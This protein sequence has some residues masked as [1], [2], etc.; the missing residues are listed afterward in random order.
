MRALLSKKNVARGVF[1]IVAAV[2]FSFIL[3]GCSEIGAFYEE[4]RL[5]EEQ[6]K[7]EAIIQAQKEELYN[8]FE[9][10][11]IEYSLGENK[12]LVVEFEKFLEGKFYNKDHIL[13]YF[14]RCER[15]NSLEYLK[16][17]EQLKSLEN[18]KDQMSIEEFEQQKKNLEI[19]Y[20]KN[21]NR[22]QDYFSKKEEEILINSMEE[23][24]VL[25]NLL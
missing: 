1:A 5:E 9:K 8:K 22:I 2:V 10:V 7:E 19:E 24:D 20:E 25:Y 14:E 13:E 17:E 3:T 15:Y 11:Y 21:K 18:A 6:Q 23:L 4:Q 16:Y 12:E